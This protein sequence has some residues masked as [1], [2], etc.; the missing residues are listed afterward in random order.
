MFTQRLGQLLAVMLFLA[1]A[2]PAAAQYRTE[3]V[4][5]SFMEMRIGATTQYGLMPMA[6]DQVR[7]DLP[8]AASVPTA[9]V[10]LRNGKPATY[11]NTTV[12]VTDADAAQGI[13]SVHVDP[14]AVANFEIIAAETVTTFALLG[15]ERVIFPGLDDE[16]LTRADIPY[17]TYGL[18]VPMW[19]ALLAE[20]LYDTEVVLRDGSHVPARHFY[21]RLADRDP[22]LQQMILAYLSD[23]H[24]VPL[25]GVLS[26]IETLGVD[27]YEES[28]IPLLQHPEPTLREA[29]LRPLA[30]SDDEHAWTAIV[31]M[32]SEDPEPGLREMAARMV[33][34]SPVGE[35]HVF[36]VFHRVASGATGARI[37]AIEEATTLDDANVGRMLRPYLA[38]PE[39]EVK[40]AAIA[41]L[42]AREEWSL[43]VDV[44]ADDT[45]D[46]P[47]R[48]M[49]ATA[50]AD[51]A[52]REERVAGLRFR[53]FNMSGEPS[54]LVI[55]AL[56]ALDD[57]D[58]RRPI[59]EFLLH[60]DVSVAVYAAHTLAERGEESSLDAL[61]EIGLDEAHPLDLRYAAGDAAY[62]V[63]IGLGTRRIQD[64][65]VARSAFLKRAAYRALGAMAA[66]GE[67]GAEVF[68]TLS[69]GLASDDA[70][71]RGASARGLGSVGTPEA[72]APIL[73]VAQDDAAGVRADVAYALANF[74]G[75]AYADQIVPVIIEFV[76]S[77]EP[78]V[79]AAA[80][81]ALG[82]LEQ[83][84][85]LS[86]VLDNISY[87]DPRVRAAAMRA[88]TDLVDPN[89]QR[90]V[91]NEITA[92]LRD[93][94]I[95]NRLL[96][97]GL[98][99]RFDSPLAVLAISQVV[100][101]PVAELRYAAITALG[102]T[103]NADAVGTLVALLEDPEREIRLASVEALR[104]LSLR[105]AVPGVEDQIGRE[106][107]PETIEAER[108]L[109]EEL[110]TRGQ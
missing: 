86:L 105:A 22:Q 31:Q 59:E 33:Q 7:P 43:M 16:G 60:P 40:E 82:A 10:I 49:V 18:Q 17:T 53:G 108:A 46:D 110:T 24:V 102:E 51:D 94:E 84:Q 74:G 73:S 62:T 76:Q 20:R 89:D 52:S 66:L 91:I 93:E 1:S 72:L 26:I 47:V 109:V 8:P 85:L 48:L 81:D 87:P 88:A 79:V 27:G 19:Q 45:L 29:A 58:P 42:H 77:G 65:A 92:G 25:F 37:A 90:P 54:I 63:L 70:G 12:T 95:A 34:A 98:L 23:D 99:G 100:N 80:L 4:V 56:N 36:E 107:D 15:V 32:M 69:Q 61:A 103:G 5:F 71:I 30:S 97:A 28:V 44:L 9:F 96:A 3:G 78:V 50:L 106:T 68:G 2:A 6:T 11:G 75:E 57:V 38:D 67:A 41:A 35:Y 21:R 13:V 39:P 83:T 101:G 104:L 55:N 64:Y 14:A